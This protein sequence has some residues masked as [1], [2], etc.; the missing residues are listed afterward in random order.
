[1][2]QLAVRAVAPA[3][4]SPTIWTLRTANGDGVPGDKSIWAHGATG[5]GV[6]GA[7]LEGWL[8][9]GDATTG[10]SAT[11]EGNHHTIYN[12]CLYRSGDD[13][14]LFGVLDSARL[15]NLR[16]EGVITFFPGDVNRSGTLA[17][18]SRAHPP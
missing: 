14:G 4:S 15:R 9:I 17:A 10:Y 18:A 7:V 13:I 11:F 3:M 12:L 2:G 5:A 1:M 8:P 6:M 16:L